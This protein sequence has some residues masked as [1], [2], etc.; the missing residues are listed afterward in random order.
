VIVIDASVAVKWFVEEAQSDEASE[1]LSRHAGEVV[2]PD[3][4]T[5]EVSAVL[6]RNA[7]TVKASRP[8][9]LAALDRFNTMIAEGD[10]ALHRSGPGDI[11][12]AAD[13]A[14]ELGHPIKDCVYLRL[15]MALDCLLVTADR[16]FAD[17]ARTIYQNVRVLGE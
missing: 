3:L 10:V 2:G 17:K 15:A 13:L 12:A 5:V 8:H 11:R 7:N 9:V 14:L 6:V 16:R 1:L 4:L